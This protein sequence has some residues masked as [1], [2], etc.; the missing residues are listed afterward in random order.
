MA[1]ASRALST[2]ALSAELLVE[3]PGAGLPG[4]SADDGSLSTVSQPD[5][6]VETPEFALPVA[7]LLPPAMLTLGDRRSRRRGELRSAGAGVTKL[8]YTVRLAS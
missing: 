5:P 8:S 1:D 6:I 7:P 4:V 3:G 2:A